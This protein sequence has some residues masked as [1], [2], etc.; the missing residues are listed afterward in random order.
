MIIH[1]LKL[2]LEEAD[3]ARRI[4]DGLGAVG[5]IKDL[6]FG[7][8]PGAVKIAGNFHVGFAVPFETQWTIDVFEDGRKLGVRLADVSVG[9]FG[10]NAATVRTH[11]MG[12]LEQKLRDVS[13]V[14]VEDGVIVLD[15]A[16]LLTAKG[17]HLASPVR[18]IE[19]KQGCVEID[20]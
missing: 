11:V 4:R 7:L 10:M 15:P 6:T 8:V 12:A 13:G 1:G 2:V 18:R 14:A 19:V 3:V 17:V 20:V 9:F 16:L 5:P